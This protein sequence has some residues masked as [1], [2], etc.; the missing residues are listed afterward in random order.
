[1]P[2]SPLTY[3]VA[4]SLFQVIFLKKNSRLSNRQLLFGLTF[5]LAFLG[6]F[7]ITTA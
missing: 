1:M 2:G 6:L 5:L 3:N 7:L 4:I